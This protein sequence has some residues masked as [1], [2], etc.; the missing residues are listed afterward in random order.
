M[1]NPLRSLSFA[2]ACI[3]GVLSWTMHTQS[4]LVRPHAA[5]VGLAIVLGIAGASAANG[6]APAANPSQ[7]SPSLRE[8]FQT[9]NVFEGLKAGRAY[10]IRTPARPSEIDALRYDH[11]Q[12]AEGIA[13]E[14]SGVAVRIEGRYNRETRVVE[15]LYDGQL[16]E[17][18]GEIFPLVQIGE[19]DYRYFAYP[20]RR[21]VEHAYGQIQ[22]STQNGRI[23]AVKMYKLK[24]ASNVVP[25][26]GIVAPATNPSAS[27]DSTTY[28]LGL[29][30]FAVE[31]PRRK[32]ALIVELTPCQSGRFKSLDAYSRN[33]DAFM[34]R[35]TAALEACE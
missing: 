9:T 2:D 31:A 27:L 11:P 5:A 13:H 1:T 28:F 6:Q 8:F 19:R 21:N 24:P 33:E 4:N 34:R 25:D 15:V 23:A 22:G 7:A 35:L 12:L 3:R 29:R 17:L 16:H 10:G 32:K 26:R 30:E 20:A 14:A 18:R